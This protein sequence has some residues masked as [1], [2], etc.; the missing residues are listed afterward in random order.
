M[1]ILLVVIL[2]FIAISL[3]LCASSLELLYLV[4]SR[5]VSSSTSKLEVGVAKVGIATS[6]SLLKV[7]AFVV[8]RVRDLM[9]LIAS[10]M[11]LIDAIFLVLLLCTGGAAVSLFY[12]TDVDGSL[13]GSVNSQVVGGTSSS[14]NG[15]F[16][17]GKPTGIS[18]ESWNKA[19]DIGKKVIAFATSSILNPP[20]GKYLLYM[21]GNTGVGYADCSVFV[22]AVL[23]GA[24][25]K[26]FSGMD[27][28][29]GYDF[30]TNKKSDLK[31]YVTTYGME[32]VIR[33]KPESKIG[34]TKT[35]LSLAMPGDIL[36]T[37]GH[38]GIYVGKNENG[39]D[40][41]VHASTSDNPTCSGDIA[42]S[43]GKNL[44]VG[45]S[46]VWGDYDIIR[47]SI[48]LGK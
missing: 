30:A 35:S 44:E 32:D 5:K 19:D 46:R 14:T 36:L 40:V 41:M 33:N 8:S 21:Q 3:R 38:V 39:D 27:A 23:E 10:C 4:S 13:I 9:S 1:F 2:T 45:F 11:L 48:L 43:D 17:G 25:N 24:L 42:L 29:D 15:S 7:S 20:N 18:D 47:P 12:D 37:D 22:C 6:I 28:P 31:G 34:T 16:S 26:T